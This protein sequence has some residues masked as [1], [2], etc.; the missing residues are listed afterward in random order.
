MSGARKSS[1]LYS[2]LGLL[3]LLIL[4]GLGFF[5][6]MGGFR[7]V[8]VREGP[9]GPHTIIFATHKGP[10]ENLE[11]SW[12][13]FQSRWKEAGLKKCN[14]LSVYL[15]SPDTPPEELRTILGCTIDELSEEE[16]LHLSEQFPVFTI[17]AM[18][19]LLSEFPFRNGLSFMFGAMKVYPEFQKIME[20]R[21]LRPAVG[22]ELY[23]D[24]ESIESI[25]FAMPIREPVETFAPLKQAFQNE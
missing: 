23:G 15:D 20:E 6:Y 4:G 18:D 2:L 19:S 16:R 3:V 12:E 1:I 10:Y 24:A 22:F 14:S 9:F 21:G 13:E 17:P 25:E 8:E 5:A 7:A 11:Q